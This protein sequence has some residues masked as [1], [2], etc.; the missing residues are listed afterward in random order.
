MT[1]EE[2]AKLLRKEID[3]AV[4]RC[5]EEFAKYMAQEYWTQDC[6]D[7]SEIKGLCLPVKGKTAR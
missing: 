4:K 5:D 6:A 1:R 7:P 2:F 3:D